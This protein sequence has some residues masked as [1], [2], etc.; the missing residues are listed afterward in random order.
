MAVPIKE[1]G[2]PGRD[3]GTEAGVGLTQSLWSL[4]EKEWQWGGATHQV[5]T[6]PFFSPVTAPLLFGLSEQ[7][8][9]RKSAYRKVQREN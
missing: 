5:E 3:G 6:A 2:Y 1:G 9:G 4:A 8:I 7:Y